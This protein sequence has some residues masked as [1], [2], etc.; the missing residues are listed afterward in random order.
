MENKDNEKAK[1]KRILRNREAEV[2][3]ENNKKI[4]LIAS[5]ITIG[6]LVVVMIICIM[7]ILGENSI[8]KDSFNKSIWILIIIVGVTISYILS[9]KASFSEKYKKIVIPDIIKNIM[10]DYYY[11]KGKFIDKEL[12]YESGLFKREDGTHYT[13]SY[14]REYEKDTVSTVASILQVTYFGGKWNIKQFSGEYFINIFEEYFE[15]KLTI[16]CHKKISRKKIN[17]PLIIISGILLLALGII[18]LSIIIVYF[19]LKIITYIVVYEPDNLRKFSYK[20]GKE[21]G[22]LFIVQGSYSI[23][24]KILTSDVTNILIDFYKSSGVET[25]ISIKNN[26]LY[27]AYDTGKDLF[28]L[29]LFDDKKEK[30]SKDYELMK[31][32]KKV[33]DCIVDK[34]SEILKS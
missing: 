29:G 30:Y 8:V 31:D 1:I 28:R 24:D 11:V 34:V 6:I 21:F 20:Y 33:N 14:Y 19:V 17:I 15:E 18:G 25:N 27:I 2:E 12:Y 13:G 32:I 7:Y 16:K 3:K 23:A 22:D 9:W 10:G 26:I 4:N 5:G